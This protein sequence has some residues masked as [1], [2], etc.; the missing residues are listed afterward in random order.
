MKLIN[1]PEEQEQIEVPLKEIVIAKIE[2]LRNIQNQILT[3]ENKEKVCQELEIISSVIQDVHAMEEPEPKCFNQLKFEYNNV[4]L[5]YQRY[6]IE[7]EISELNQISEN[8]NRNLIILE[9][10]QKDLKNEQIKFEEQQKIL[11]KQYNKTE[12]KNGNLVYNLLGFLASFSI[13]S[14]SVSAIG[15]IHGMLYIMIFILF[16]LLVL[17]TTLIGLHNFY[18]NKDKKENKLQDNYFLWKIVA[19]ILILLCLIVPIKY[20]KDNKKYIFNY[21]DKKIENVIEEKVNNKLEEN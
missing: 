3:I 13:V 6:E 16:T 19:G 18:I 17:I 1:V 4:K 8:I 15:Q 11:E 9:E 5:L 2:I 10:K 12:E 14:A 21:I 20:L 7:E